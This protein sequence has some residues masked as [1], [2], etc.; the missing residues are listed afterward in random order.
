MPHSLSP[1]APKTVEWAKAEVRETLRPGGKI[2]SD[3][4]EREATEVN[5][6]CAEI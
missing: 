2:L 4:A 3:I 6:P 1:V 5:A